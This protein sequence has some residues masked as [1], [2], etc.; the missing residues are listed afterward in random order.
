MSGK[1][2]SSVGSTLYDKILSMQMNKQMSTDQKIILTLDGT[3]ETTLRIITDSEIVVRV[4]R[5]T[6][7]K[8]S[9]QRESLIV[10]R[11]TDKPLIH[12][13]TTVFPRSLPET[14][15]HQIREKKKGIGT[16]ISGIETRRKIYEIG[17]TSDYEY[18]YKRYGIFHNKELA[19]KIKEKIMI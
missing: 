1:K 18:P 17:W 12:A 2:R 15:I 9:I 7:N 13:R 3:A 10:N 6:E 16:I 8:Q 5:Q 4:T 19:F 11:R 14:I